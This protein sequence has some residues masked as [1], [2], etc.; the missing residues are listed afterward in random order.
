MSFTEEKRK[1]IIKYMLDKIRSNDGDVLKKTAD[2]FGISE[3]SVRRYVKS[4]A[5]R[6]IL[7]EDSLSACGYRLAETR[8][9]R[10]CGLR[11]TTNPDNSLAH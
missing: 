7:Q 2:N 4:C 11:Q 10:P 1:A 8:S 9:R 6:G 3:T 5:E